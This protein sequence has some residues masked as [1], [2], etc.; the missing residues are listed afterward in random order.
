MTQAVMPPPPNAPEIGRWV[1]RYYL[2]PWHRAAN[3]R[4]RDAWQQ[5]TVVLEYV[6]DETLL[7]G[8]DE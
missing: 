2:C 8:G 7:K 5:K 4:Y 3:N 1:F 6:D